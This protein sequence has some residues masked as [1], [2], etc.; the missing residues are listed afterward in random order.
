MRLKLVLGAALLALANPSFA[1][2]PPF[3]EVDQ[4]GDGIITREEAA[5]HAEISR[6]FDEIDRNQDGRL[7]RA[8]YEQW[9]AKQ[10]DQAPAGAEPE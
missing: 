6:Q 10:D 8:E 2:A 1:Q 3:A 7:D 4:D 9:A 5:Q